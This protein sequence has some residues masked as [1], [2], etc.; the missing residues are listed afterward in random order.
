MR[1]I[2]LSNG[3]LLIALDH[4]GE[5]RDLYFPRVGLEDHVRGRMRHR[6]GVW[7]DGELSWLSEDPRWHISVLCKEES[8][9]SNITA[10]N[11]SL[12]IELSFTDVVYNESPIF[13]RRVLVKNTAGGSREI[14]VYFAHQFEIYRAHGGDTAYFD[15]INHAVVHYK[16]QR[17][18]MMSGLCDED[19]FSD[20]AVGLVNFEDKEGTHR[21]AEDGVLSKN[22]IEHGPVDS[23]IGFYATYGGGEERPIHYWLTAGRSHAQAQ[24]LHRYVI[25]K[26]P[27]HLIQ[28][29]SDYW[30]AWVNKYHWSFY[31][32]SPE[33]AAL[34][35]RSLM[36]VR[37]HVDSGGGVIASSDSDMLQ[38]GKDTYAYIWPRDASYTALALDRAGDANVAERFFAFCNRVIDERGFFMHKYLPDD[39][40]GS[41]WEPWVQNGV[42]QYPIQED[43]TASVIFALREH[44]SRSRD[45]EFI[46]D[47]YNSLVEK[48]ANF[49]VGYRDE[50]TGLPHA[51]HDLWEEKYGITTYTSSAVFGALEAAAQIA[52]MLGKKDRAAHY[53]Q[54]AEEMRGGILTHLFDEQT[55]LF[56]KM[57]NVQNGA[58]VRDT[59]IDMSSVYGLLTFGVLPPDDPRLVSAFEKTVATLSQNRPFG[60]LP[61]YEHDRYYANGSEPNSWVITTLWYAEY[62]IAR[63]HTEADMTQVR[64]IFAWVVRNALPSGVLSEQVDCMTGELLSAAPLTWS[65]ASFINAVLRYLDRLEELGVCSACDPVA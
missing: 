39:S 44:Y 2:V 41:S 6:V 21:D 55:G 58:I 13:L 45:L 35:K 46:E 34:F 19:P 49:M 56:L 38:R 24:E 43:E 37:A 15:P 65:H 23:V 22:P 54:A 31:G 51:S 30:R 26:T 53:K 27:D 57:I 63:A 36:Y 18:F 48:A 25:K 42:L 9:A 60:G 16:G 29:T 61:R 40:L 50:M 10:I 62:L 3:S 5:V 52:D 17:V 12:G 7:V 32:L 28:T 20:Y 4:F 64:E 33:V 59:T 14:K 8:L 47:L 1:S 11:T